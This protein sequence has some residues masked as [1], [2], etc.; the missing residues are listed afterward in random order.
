MCT[1][2]KEESGIQ[3]VTRIVFKPNCI[4]AEDCYVC[5]FQFIL[6]YSFIDYNEV[7]YGDYKYPGWA[8]S[9]GWLMTICVILGIIVTAVVQFFRY[10]CSDDKVATGQTLRKINSF[11]GRAI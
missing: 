4:V 3:K 8:E 2:T 7:T 10:L 5:S 1:K 11:G 6:I 9:L